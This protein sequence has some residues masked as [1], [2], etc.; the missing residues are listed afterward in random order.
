VHG[1]KSDFGYR[2]FIFV[3]PSVSKREPLLGKK[4]K[5]TFKNLL[6]A[7]GYSAKLVN[8]FWKWCDKEIKCLDIFPEVHSKRSW[9]ALSAA[10]KKS[11]Y[12]LLL[13]EAFL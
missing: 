1:Y 5:P 6:V 11:V 2:T 9:R 3:L 7:N 8:E 12:P 13:S 10:I 4:I